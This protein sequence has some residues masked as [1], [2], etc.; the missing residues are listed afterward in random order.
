MGVITKRIASYNNTLSVDNEEIIQSLC[1]S[2]KLNELPKIKEKFKSS[3]GDTLKKFFKGV[4]EERDYLKEQFQSWDLQHKISNSLGNNILEGF[5]EDEIR[6]IKNEGEKRYVDEVP[7]GYRDVGKQSNKYGDLIIWKEILR[8][9]GSKNCSIIFISR[10]LKEDWIL[11]CNG[12]DCG[13]RQEL[14]NEF[15]NVST[16]SFVIYTLDR[17]LEYANKEQNV[18]NDR[19]LEDAI[20]I[21]STLATTLNA[22]HLKG[23]SEE[24][25]TPKDNAKYSTDVSSPKNYEIIMA[26]EVIPSKAKDSV[27]D[28]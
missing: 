19:D 15:K 9:A 5:S 28:D 17:F 25:V 23:V 26:N 12:M 7:P 27:V 16:G 10:D 3:I 8:F 4:E 21:L 24:E 1:N 6:S 20:R 13:P 18:L 2:L 11:R 22:Q 14:L